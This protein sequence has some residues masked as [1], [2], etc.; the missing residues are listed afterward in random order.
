MRGLSGGQRFGTIFRG[1]VCLSSLR[2][3]AYFEPKAGEVLFFAF[4]GMS[5]VLHAEL[6]LVI[7]F[8]D[9]ARFSSHGTASKSHSELQA[10]D[11][12]R[13]WIEDTASEGRC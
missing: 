10:F 7:P 13:A 6:S 4:R 5:W 9:S 3:L 12:V 8:E 11:M 2:I 1:D